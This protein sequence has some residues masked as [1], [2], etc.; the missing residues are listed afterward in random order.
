MNSNVTLLKTKIEVGSVVITAMYRL[1]ATV[2]KIIDEK[3]MVVRWHGNGE[4]SEVLR[5]AFV[6]A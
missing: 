1:K 2:I 5:I 4:E 3:T 6:L